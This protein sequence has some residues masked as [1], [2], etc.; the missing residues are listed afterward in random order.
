M[1]LAKKCDRCGKMYEH[2][3]TGA[4][5]TRNAIAR[6]TISTKGEVRGNDTPMDLC[7]E[8]MAE[9]DKFMTNGGKF[10]DKT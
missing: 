9:F 6:V 2:Y 3:P 10:D 1:A 8:C 7:K 5:I 4:K